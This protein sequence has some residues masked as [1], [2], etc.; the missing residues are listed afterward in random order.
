MKGFPIVTSIYIYIYIYCQDNIFLQH[1]IE[2]DKVIFTTVYIGYY[3]LNYIHLT[4]A[5]NY[6]FQNI[7]SWIKGIRNTKI[8]MV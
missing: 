4:S 1:F 8:T 6:S 5:I 3:Y 7:L 2:H